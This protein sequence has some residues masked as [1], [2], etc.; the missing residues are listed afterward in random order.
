MM[1]E[2]GFRPF[3]DRLLEAGELKAVTAAVDA[4]HEL[5]QVVRENFRRNGPALKFERVSGQAVPLVSG[6]LATR[7][8]IAL[9]LGVAEDAVTSTLSER[10]KPIPARRVKSGPCK[11]VRLGKPDLNVLPSP[12]WHEEDAGP[13]FGTLA[14]CVTV[15]AETG[16]R[17]VGIYRAMVRDDRTFS[18]EFPPHKDIARHIRQYE[19]RGEPM[20]IALAIG[21]DPVL[22]VLSAAPLPYEEDEYEVWGA[23]TGSPL[24]V[25]A[26]ETSRLEVP[27]DAEIVV[28]AR[29]LAGRREP[30]G[31]F[32]EHTG[33][34]STEGR[35]PVFEVTAI[36]HRE[37]PMFH[38]TD[39]GR[40]PNESA[41]LRAVGRGAMMFRALRAMGVPGIVDVAVLPEGGANFIVVVAAHATYKGQARQVIHAACTQEPVGAKWIIVV[42]G[43]VNPH[44]WNEVTWCLWS[45]VQP[46]RDLFVTPDR[47]VGNYL[48]PSVDPSQRGYTSKVCIDATTV[49]KGFDFPPLAEP[50]AALKERVKSRWREYGLP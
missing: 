14:S 31:P 28:E 38:G 32:G 36:T 39:E 6:T 7:R 11:A 41:T 16:V 50:S 18:V 4:R 1:H 43:D 49:F 33:Y 24:D 35:M 46:Q 15:D 17:N 25:V 30:E 12:V 5:G 42:D 27:A 9:A 10:R 21:V 40:P 47:E 8:R 3:L 2:P 19:A 44:D 29:A 48:D 37:S 45:R 23:L 13:Y 26:C 22:T 34:Y 20:P